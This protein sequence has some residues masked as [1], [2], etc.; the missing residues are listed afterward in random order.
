MG[1]E[2]HGA[3]R[4][5]PAQLPLGDRGTERAFTAIKLHFSGCILLRKWLKWGNLPSLPMAT[6]LL[7]LMGLFVIRKI[8]LFFR[9]HCSPHPCCWLLAEFG[10]YFSR[11]EAVGPKSWLAGV[12]FAM[13]RSS[14]ISLTSCDQSGE[15]EGCPQVLHPVV[16]P[17][18]SNKTSSCNFLNTSPKTSRE[19]VS[20]NWV[21][22]TKFASHWNAGKELKEHC[23]SLQ[24]GNLH[25]H[26]FK[27][28]RTRNIYCIGNC[29]RLL[30]RL[31]PI[32]LTW[33]FAG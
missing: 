15:K 31:T 9:A 23:L 8:T 11:K 5:S 2:T 30:S 14:F 25:Y 26:C 16:N 7:V 28:P 32:L 29:W 4:V 12:K 17:K 1:I 21:S 10:I 22:M 20:C 33:H 3:P 6:T 18:K 19:S 13:T 27:A 24:I